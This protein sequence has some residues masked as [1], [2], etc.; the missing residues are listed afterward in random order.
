MTFDR[1]EHESTSWDYGTFISFCK[2]FGIIEK[3]RFTRED[4][5]LVFKKHHFKDL[6]FDHFKEC[7]KM[8]SGGLVK[9]EKESYIDFSIINKMYK[10][11]KN[12]GKKTGSGVTEEKENE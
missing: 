10:L 8:I 1:V 7:L 2:H 11:K 9:S 5:L 12:Y 3:R 6:S 4:A